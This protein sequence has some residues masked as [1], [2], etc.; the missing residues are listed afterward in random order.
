MFEKHLWKSDILSKDVDH[1]LIH[2]D[3][4]NLLIHNVSDTMSQTKWSDTL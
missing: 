3:A 2:N 4:G 1:R